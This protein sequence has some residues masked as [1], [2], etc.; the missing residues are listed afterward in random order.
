MPAW[1]KCLARSLSDFHTARAF[2]P[3]QESR[4]VGYKHRIASLSTLKN[5]LT[6]A[7]AAFFT[8]FRVCKR[9]KL[10]AMIIII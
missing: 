9:F 7:S 3:G 5:I 10:K 8:P 2:L 6:A 4:M 1:P